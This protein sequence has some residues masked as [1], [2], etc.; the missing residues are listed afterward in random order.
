[1]AARQGKGAG[2]WAVRFTPWQRLEHLVVML[3][4]TALVVTGLPQKFFQ[5]RWA[6]AVVLAL[7]GIE[8]VRLVHRWA[9]ILFAAAAVLHLAIILWLVLV[10]HA[11]PSMV[12][13][14][15]DARDAIG[16][17]RYCVGLSDAHPTFDR[18]DY[19]QK[20]EYWGVI[21]GS[22]VMVVTGF[23]LYFPI[24]ATRWLP[25]EIVPAAKV[26]HS[27]EALLAFLVIVIWHM[28]SAHFNPDVFPVDTSIF[29]GRISLE[30]LHHE[31]ALEYRRL[32][33][34]GDAA[35]GSVDVAPG[36]PVPAPAEAHGETG[37]GGPRA[38]GPGGPAP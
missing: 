12:P 22:L 36:A 2:G 3:L 9:G 18:Y 14:R 8:R 34:G 31:H 24:A 38:F 17:L 10:R 20:F 15:A 32:F 16:M 19:R 1:M 7:G 4:F 27:N 25:G 13:N 37:L 11:R 33:P 28:Y 26:A 35:A 6:D 5:A 21:F 30:R 29:T 23:I